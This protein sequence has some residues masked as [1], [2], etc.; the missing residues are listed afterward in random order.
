MTVVPDMKL[1]DSMSLPTAYCSM[2]QMTELHYPACTWL[3]RAP[4]AIGGAEY[5]AYLDVHGALRPQMI[6]ALRWTVH[7]Y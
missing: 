6:G 2:A 7:S 3:V 5:V 4:M 1:L